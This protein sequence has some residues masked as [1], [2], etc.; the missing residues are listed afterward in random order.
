MRRVA[1]ITAPGIEMA[2]DVANYYSR[3]RMGQPDI[4]VGT[5]EVVTPSAQL[6]FGEAS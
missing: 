3:D 1:D 5:C 6:P 4:L 2:V